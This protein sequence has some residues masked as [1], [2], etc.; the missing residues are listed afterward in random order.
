MVNCR[1]R[2]MKG[3]ERGG[4]KLKIGFVLLRQQLW[5]KCLPGLW[6]VR[7]RWSARKHCGSALSTM[8]GG[9]DPMF[10]VI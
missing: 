4:N 5:S 6:K 7:V 8:Q 9:K 3:T 10:F 2:F 1:P